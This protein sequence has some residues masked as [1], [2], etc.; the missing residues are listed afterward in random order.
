MPNLEAEPVPQKRW[1]F[2]ISRLLGIT[3]VYAVMASNFADMPIRLLLISTAIVTICVLYD[4]AVFG[5]TEANGPRWCRFL[6]SLAFYS[7]CF[8]LCNFIGLLVHTYFPEAR[9]SKSFLQEVVE[10]F[11]GAF[12]REFGRALGIVLGLWLGT[13]IFSL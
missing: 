3:A 2:S 12:L 9:P 6:M 11:N 10:L 4:V 1:Q 8:S 13:G 7:A 5:R